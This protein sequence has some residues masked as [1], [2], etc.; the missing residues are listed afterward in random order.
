MLKTAL[1]TSTVALKARPADQISAMLSSKKGKSSC[2]W[3]RASP[4]WLA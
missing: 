3:K 4:P 1:K 2:K